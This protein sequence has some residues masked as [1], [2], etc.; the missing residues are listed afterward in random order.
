MSKPAFVALGDIHLDT[1]IW[2]QIS[3]VT[4]DALLGYESFLAKAIEL[5]VPAV[6]VGDLFDA[7]K[8]ASGLIAFHRRM[9]DICAAEK[10]PVYFIQGNHDKQIVPWASATHE[11]PIWVGNGQPFSIGSLTCVGFDYNLHDAIKEQIANMPKCDV[12]FLHQALKQALPFD[13]AWNCDLDWFTDEERCKLVVVADIHKPHNF[14]MSGDRRAYY[15]GPGHARDVDQLGPKSVLVVND[16][17]KVKRADIPYRHI[18]TFKVQNKD[19]LE[20]LVGWL[21]TRPSDCALKPFAWIAHTVDMV[22]SMPKPSDYPNIIFKMD[23]VAH[24]EDASFEDMTAPLTEDTLVTVPV[25]LAKL[26]DKT[27]D[28]E[29]YE[30]ACTIMG[31]S[32]PIADIITGERNK[33]FAA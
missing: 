31:S 6:I 5:K 32:S 10:I 17:L 9:M 20:K 11:H 30:L 29:A 23:P 16:D 18:E 13:G 4:G 22:D 28:K 33:A 15:T 2:K 12:L 1:L 21:T 26:I 25:L 27:A 3:A 7:T 19:D 14:P 24:L 8:P